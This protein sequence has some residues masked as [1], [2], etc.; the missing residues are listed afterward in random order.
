MKRE[1]KTNMITTEAQ[2]LFLRYDRYV[3]CEAENHRKSTGTS[4]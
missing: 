1:V 3:R 2:A 4:R